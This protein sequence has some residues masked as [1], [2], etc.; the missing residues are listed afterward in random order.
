MGKIYSLVIVKP[1]SHFPD[2]SQSGLFTASFLAE[3]TD[4]HNRSIAFF[5]QEII[6]DIKN[7]KERV[8]GGADEIG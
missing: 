5:I 1:R 4:I 7:A 6:T 2:K 3:K 8:M